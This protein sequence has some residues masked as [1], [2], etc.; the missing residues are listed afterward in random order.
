M[1]TLTPNFAQSHA[2]NGQGGAVVIGN[3]SIGQHAH[4]PLYLTASE[5]PYGFLKFAQP[6]PTREQMIQAPWMGPRVAILGTA[7]SSRM[8]APFNDPSWKIWGCSP[9]NQNIFPRIDC[10]FELHA[11]L[12]WPQCESYGRPYLA[13]LAQQPF[14]LFMQDQSWLA[15]AITFPIMELIKEFGP[16]FFTSSF[17]EMAALAIWLGAKELAMYGIDMAS[18]DEYILQRPGGFYFIQEGARRGCTVWA[19]L[20]SDMMQPPGIYGY[21]ERTPYGRKNAV[22]EYELRDRIAPMQTQKAGLE[23]DL[24]YLGGALENQDYQRSIW[25]GVQDNRFAV[26]YLTRLRA[27]SPMAAALAVPQPTA[28]PSSLSLPLTATVAPTKRKPGRPRKR[29]VPSAETHPAG[30]G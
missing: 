23:R 19:P 17:T 21:S 25:G 4:D 18:R 5:E 13:W 26:D 15:R 10:W 2:A 20:E 30:Q 29:P 9:G 6:P 7:P 14:P 24:T 1:T 27:Q 3:P 8:L 12:L 11:N 28:P 16:Y 22:R